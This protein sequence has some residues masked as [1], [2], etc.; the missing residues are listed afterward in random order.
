MLYPDFERERERER[1]RKNGQLF[2]LP[3][4]TISETLGQ[5]EA[6]QGLASKSGRLLTKLIHMISVLMSRRII[7]SDEKTIETKNAPP[8]K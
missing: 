7:V 3:P 5:G 2:F 1:E 6:S 4:A 8:R